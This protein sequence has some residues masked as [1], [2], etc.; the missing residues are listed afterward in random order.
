MLFDEL[1]KYC[2]NK[3]Q[4]QQRQGSCNPCTHDSNNCAGDCGT[5]LHEIHFPREYPNGRKK[6]NCEKIVNYYVCQFSNKFASEILYALYSFDDM[7]EYDSLNIVSIGCGPAP[8]LMAFEYYNDTHNKFPITYYGFDLNEKWNPIHKEIENY[9]QSKN[10]FPSFYYEEVFRLFGK[11]H[12]KRETN[13]N[14]L[15]L[16]YV[17]SHYLSTGTINELCNFY[18]NLTNNV[19]SKMAP[20]STII[21]NDVNSCYCGRDSL[22]YLIKEIKKKGITINSIEKRCFDKSRYEYGNEYPHKNLLMTYPDNFRYNY[23]CWNDCSCAQLI[24]KLGG[25]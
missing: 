15:I 23:K 14:F 12:L 16:Q 11:R 3:Y 24:I 7:N 8:D 10:I 9:C 19:I 5:C 25:K 20:K 6:Y 1:I 18:K 4:E 13:S 2:D 21:I 22:D 17:I